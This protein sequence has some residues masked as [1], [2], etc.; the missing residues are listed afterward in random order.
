MTLTECASLYCSLSTVHRSRQL[1]RCS[2]S[3]IIVYWRHNRCTSVVCWLDVALR[4]GHP[5]EGV[6]AAALGAAPSEDVAALPLELPLLA[7]S[8][9]ESD[10]SDDT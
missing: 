3:G 7:V 5:S 1:A 9:S 8:G 4:R 10:A 6:S 2:V